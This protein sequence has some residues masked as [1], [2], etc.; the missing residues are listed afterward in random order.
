MKPPPFH[1]LRSEAPGPGARIIDLRQVPLSRKIVRMAPGKEKP[2]IGK[3]CGGR[4][5][6]RST[7]LSGRMPLSTLGVEHL[8]TEMIGRRCAPAPMSKDFS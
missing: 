1:E 8:T 5:E 3:H 7:K 4:Q 2:A 6:E